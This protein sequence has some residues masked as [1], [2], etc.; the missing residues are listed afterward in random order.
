MSSVAYSMSEYKEDNVDDVLRMCEMKSDE[1]V[2][3]KHL[4]S[5]LETYHQQLSTIAEFA[6][7][8]DS[9]T[10]VQKNGFRTFVKVCTS[11]KVLLRNDAWS[12]RSQLFSFPSFHDQ[13]KCV[14]ADCCY[15]VKDYRETLPKAKSSR[16]PMESASEALDALS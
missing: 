4:T 3:G 7:L 8:Y 14:F 1:N 5:K 12:D 13:M 11:S 10:G 15:F 16:C 2:L 6:P 9:K